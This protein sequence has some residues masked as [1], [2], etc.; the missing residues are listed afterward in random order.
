MIKCISCNTNTIRKIIDLGPNPP[1]NRYLDKIDENCEKHPIEF[2]YCSSCGLL[3][4]VNAMPPEIVKSRFGWI[5]YNEPEAHLDNLVNLLNLKY[6]YSPKVR[7]VGLTYKDDST[8][9][10]FNKMGIKDT[11]RLK[12]SED[13]GIDDPFASLETIQGVLNPEKAGEIAERIDM[14]D[15]ILVRHIL[16]HAHH[17]R[18]LLEACSSL[19]K[20]GG[21]LVFEVPDCR[22]MLNGH[23]HCFLWEEHISY[24]TPE[25]LR[26][27]FEHAGFRDFEIRIYSYPMEDSLVAIVRNVASNPLQTN[28]DVIHEISPLENFAGSFK[29]RGIKIRKYLQNLQSQGQ[30]VALFGAGHVAVKFINFYNLSSCLIGVIDDNPNKIGRFMPGS[31]LQIFS[32]DCLDSGEIKL[33]LS[34]LNPESEKKVLKANAGYLS[35]GGKFCSIFSAGRNNIDLNI[36]NVRN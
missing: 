26:L 15:I 8:L 33:C 19:V 34:A 22:K 10:R 3:Q 6:G 28:N 24:F 1:S 12:Q 31:Q 5:T 20:P 30:S 32:S 17:P 18:V 4:L 11:Y 21:L 7:I 13:L 23:D 9:L 29:S 35:L 25:T 36:N 16:E 27:F 2:A 14:A